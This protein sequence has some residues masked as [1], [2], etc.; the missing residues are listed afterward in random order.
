M[1]PDVEPPGRD[2]LSF[3]QLGAASARPERPGVGSPD[4]VVVG[5]GAIGL[6]SAWRLAQR[7][8]DVH[9]VDPE[10]GRGAS[11]VAA[12]M[13][14]PVTEARLGE[15][16]LLRLGLASAERWP[17]FTGEVEAASD[18]SVGYRADG[19]VVVALDADDRA[20]LADLVD[21][22]RSLGLDVDDLQARQVRALEPALAPGVRRGALAAGERSVDPA[23]LVAALSV[24]VERAGATFRRDHVAA[25]LSVPT[26]SSSSASP[27]PAG[28]G[29]SIAAA[30]ELGERRVVGV[31]LVGGERISTGVVVLATG[32]WSADL[33]GLPAAARP[34]VRPV[35]GQVV[36]LRQRPG[37]TL[38]RHTVRAFVRGSVVYLVPR[39]D[40]RVV[41][42]ATVEE[43]GWDSSV[44]A[45]GA[46][47]LLRDAITVFPGLDEAELVGVRVGFRPGTPDDLPLI[48]ASLVDG[49]VVAT[50]HYRNGILLTPI[51]AEAVAAVVSGS[52]VP[53]EV[54]PCD[55][56]R[57]HRTDDA[58]RG[59][60]RGVRA[61]LSEMRR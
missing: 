40:G 50:G 46:Y 22:Q 57:F 10:P 23:A 29:G 38:V 2:R 21:R 20:A 52:A 54:D 15:L 47:E 19:T 34:P 14:A 59:A 26:G 8:L 9:V 7:G 41:C 24:A 4:A 58:G 44:T 5:G 30:A 35:K 53:A 51:T 39:D 45:G 6:A 42:G 27:S 3:D 32:A 49:L 60:G 11:G 25:L 56:Q 17:A 43:R 12:G 18:R 1:S 28:G 31:E 36:T 55:A 37:D 61:D 48:G 16:D 13:L 33:A